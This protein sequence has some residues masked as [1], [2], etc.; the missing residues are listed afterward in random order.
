MANNLTPAAQ[1]LRM[2]TEHQQYS[3]EN[4]AAAIQ[5]YA[6]F[7]GFEI[8]QTYSDPA[9]SGVVLKRRI[10]L[11][12]L[13]QDVVSGRTS[14]KVILVYDVSRWGRFQDMDESAH[15]E[16]LWKSAG[17]PVHYCS[18]I[19]AND[20]AL[21]N[22]I[23]KALKRT[24]AGE[25][26]RE[27][28][29]K[30][31]AGQRRIAKLGFKQGGAAGYG[32]RRMLV[33]PDRR[34]K[35]QLQDRDRKSLA[36]DRVTLVPGPRSE[37][38][39]VHEMYRMLVF[40]GLSV[41][42]I[43]NELNRRG[44]EFAPDSM[45]DYAAVYGVLTGLKYIGCYAFGRTSS[46]LYTPVI[47]LP[48]SEW[49][50]VSGAFEPIV[51]YALYAQAQELLYYRSLNKSDEELLWMLRRLLQRE[52]RLSGSLI[53]RSYGISSPSTY[54]KRFG[55]LQRAYELIG[56]GRAEQ[57]GPIDGRRRTQALR[58]E[59]IEKLV[60]SFPEEL[61]IINRGGRWRPQMQLKGGTII[62]VLVAPS[63]KLHSGSVRWKIR[64][65]PGELHR[66]T[67]LARLDSASRSFLDF[68]VLPSIDRL[69]PFQIKECDSWLKRGV[70]LP[71]LN[72]FLNVLFT[73]RSP[74]SQ[75]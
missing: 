7:N 9:R 8:A 28:S 51:D 60:R 37:I 22:L 34:P 1:Y 23:M 38:K 29:A 50:V 48:K 56:Y 64:P 12:K 42:G 2:S 65:A 3:M 43:A 49:I 35:Q 33:G 62:S 24:M 54:T 20:L 40:D 31:I 21:P 25:Y 45:W 70:D 30:V 39:V 69:R 27:L 57:F 32:L 17:I 71:D 10:G 63:F 73:V 53:A 72:Q 58:R 26:S 41:H 67:L 14:Y 44:I 11:Q 5:T 75:T 47:M 68:H 59:L 6:E 19:F 36:T 66:A 61:S 18:E 4:Q 13:L 55:S 74:R 52:G 16:F 15:Y 46:K